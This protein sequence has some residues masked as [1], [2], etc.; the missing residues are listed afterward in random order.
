MRS[1]AGKDLQIGALV[2]GT[3]ILIVGLYASTMRYQDAFR[4]RADDMPRWTALTDGV[5]ERTKPV[6]SQMDLLKSAVVAEIAAKKTQ[7]ITAELL[8]QKIELRAAGAA[9][10]TP[11]TP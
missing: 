9:S 3:M 8:K 5:I 10:E 1:A 2:A 7:M 4:Q 6:R 11:E